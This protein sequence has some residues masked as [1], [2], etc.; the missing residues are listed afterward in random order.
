[1][2]DLC[3]V[4]SALVDAVLAA[5][6]PNG[7]SERSAVGVAVKVF[8]GV[9]DSGMLTGM[10]GAAP[11]L[12]SVAAVS[13]GTRNTTRWGVQSYESLGLPGITATDMGNSATYAGVALEGDLAGLL[14]EQQ[15][16]VYAAQKG[17]AASL[18][19]AVL[20]DAV[21]SFTI[22]WLSGARVTVPAA[23]S[24]V[25][26]TA[27]AAR[28][29]EEYSR[30]EQDFAVGVWASSPQ[31]RDAVC[32]CIGPPLAACAF[33]PLRDGTGG[34][35][36]YSATKLSDRDQASSVYRRELIYSVEYGTTWAVSRPAMLFGDACVNG[37][38]IYV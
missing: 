10:S 31:L 32:S 36:R 15:A 25:A 11:A 24:V 26:R 20:A 37:Q 17:D 16:F 23:G 7:P 29:L 9:P 34:R 22:C 18:V 30:Q 6:Y 2:A 14:V 12:V 28:C 1:M 27:A 38:T 35:L 21:R 3:D 19:A 8:R 5:L 13:G 33:L 4:E